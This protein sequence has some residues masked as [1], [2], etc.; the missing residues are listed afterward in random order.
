MLQ[1]TIE[2]IA[3]LRSDQRGQDLVEYALIAGLAASS[4]IAISSAVAATSIQFGG[5]MAALA[6]AIALTASFN[7]NG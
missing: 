6:K 7:Y 3:R 2:K 4:A 5:V 1:S